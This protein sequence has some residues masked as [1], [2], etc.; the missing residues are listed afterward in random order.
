MVR[1]PSSA[2]LRRRCRSQS[3]PRP[4]PSPST[5]VVGSSPTRWRP[6]DLRCS[7]RSRP[8]RHGRA[9]A[10]GGQRP[11][12]H[13][14]RGHG[15]APARRGVRGVVLVD[16]DEGFRMMSRV[17]G[18]APELVRI[19]LRVRVAFDGEPARLR[20]GGG[21]VRGAPMRSRARRSPTSAR[22]RPSPHGPHG[23]GL[24]ASARGLRPERRRRRRAVRGDDPGCRWRRS[25]WA[26]SSASGRASTDATQIG[27]ASAMAHV[28][29][30]ARRSPP[31]CATWRSSP[32]AARSGPSGA[33]APR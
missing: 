12:G 7:R 16:L 25:T 30:G 15:R 17:D 14:L 3:P 5:A 6:T 26:S 24:P 27:G 23:P 28:D 18:V 29:H 10:R 2:S 22:S 20:A 32:T 11:E 13:R 21:R 33:R 8:S 4:R 19:G 31:G 1:A 9:A